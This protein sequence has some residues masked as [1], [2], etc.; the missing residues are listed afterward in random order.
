MA[1]RLR[2]PLWASRVR[3]LGWGLGNHGGCLF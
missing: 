1:S 2:A 3:F